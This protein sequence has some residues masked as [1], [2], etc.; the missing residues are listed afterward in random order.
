[1]LQGAW[2]ARAIHVAV[3]LGLPELLAGGPRT[4]A[5]L[6]DETGAHAPSLRRLLRLLASTGVFTD[7]RRDDLFGQSELSE[8]LRFD[9]ASPVATDAR[10][11]AAHWHWRAWERLGH[12]IRTG[13]DA[14][15]HANGVSFW[16]KTHDDP[17]ARELFAAAMDAVSL[18]ESTLVP[19]VHD[20][21]ASRTVVDIGGGRGSLVAA[22]LERHEHVRGVILERPNTLEQARR[23][24]T[25]RGVVDRCDL[26][27]GDFF[28]TI[29]EGADT[30]VIKHVLHD[31][32]DDDVVRVLHRVAAR[33]GEQS[34]LLVID[35]LLDEDATAS[36]LCVDMLL[37]VL[38]G[39]VERSEAEM[40][41]LAEKAGLRQH[42]SVAVGPGPQ[43]IVEYRRA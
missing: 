4:A 43:R 11:Q 21:S 7:L 42:H 20:F 6:A 34:R 38:V 8:V 14:F 5:E 15:E 35:N 24:L 19:E 3:E 25:E 27:P 9:P 33:M 13:R 12:S 36:S 32:G 1:M 23:L 18:V 30:Y 29:P 22:I 37:L 17:E 39:G 41:A 26:V 10:F 40:T 28:D 31:W 16:T 2:K